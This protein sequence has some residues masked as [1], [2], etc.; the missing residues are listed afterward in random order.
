M[1]KAD[2]R[3][4]PLDPADFSDEQRELVG[5]WTH[6]NFSRVIV[7]HPAAYRVFL[8]YID[9]MIRQTELTPRDREVLVLR[10]LAFSD[11]VYEAQHHEMIAH[12]AQMSDAEIAAIRGDGAGLSERDLLLM[13]AADELI[14]SH[15]LG[16]ATWAEL[17]AH[18]NDVQ[19]MEIVF[20]VGC[21]TVMA[22]TTNSFGIPLEGS[23][24]SFERI[25]E[26]RDYT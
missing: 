8:P 12:N 16:E 17:A 26:L 9:K 22:M 3:I 6:L 4:P 13:R 21:Y 2:I 5:E 14:A 20:L 15:H 18:Y 25:T 11:E 19:L 1:P 24:A 23:D 10:T 7:N